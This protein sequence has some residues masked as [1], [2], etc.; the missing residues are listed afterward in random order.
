MKMSTKLSKIS[1][2]DFASPFNL[3]T[4]LDILGLSLATFVAVATM[5]VMFP[6][7]EFQW[8]LKIA[9]IA[10]AVF[11]A[12]AITLLVHRA[13]YEFNVKREKA[14]LEMKA[15]RENK[16]LE[17]Y[18]QD[19]MNRVTEA[20]IKWANNYGIK[21]EQVKH[22]PYKNTINFKDFVIDYIEIEI[23]SFHFMFT[24]RINSCEVV[25]DFINFLKA[26]KLKMVFVKDKYHLG[27]KSKIKIDE[28][29]ISYIKSTLVNS[30]LAPIY[31][32]AYF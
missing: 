3:D 10:G 11:A 22:S 19:Q 2:R 29:G 18:L 7:N 24:V 6:E 20:I 14:K 4:S 21:C 16:T 27:P 13:K 15:K 9:E 1:L 23:V 28:E 12:C 5:V 31:T 26:S 25:R 30:I 17:K 32:S 8:F